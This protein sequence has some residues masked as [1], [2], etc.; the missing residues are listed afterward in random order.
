MR[1][2]NARFRSKRAETFIIVRSKVRSFAHEAL[3]RHW[4]PK[5]NPLFGDRGHPVLTMAGE[6]LRDAICRPSAQAGYAADL[7]V[8]ETEGQEEC[9]LCCSL[10]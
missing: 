8:R 4:H 9:H 10:R 7:L 1:S 2:R 6:E 3:I 5:L